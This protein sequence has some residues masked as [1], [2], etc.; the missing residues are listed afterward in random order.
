MQEGRKDDQRR[1]TWAKKEENVTEGGL[2]MGALGDGR[3]ERVVGRKRVKKKLRKRI[4]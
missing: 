3:W 1:E 4:L 2:G